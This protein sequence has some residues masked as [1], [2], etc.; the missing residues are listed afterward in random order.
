MSKQE[1]DL[2]G[3]LRGVLENDLPIG[4]AKVLRVHYLNISDERPGAIFQRECQSQLRT[5]GGL[6][7]LRLLTQL[8]A[9]ESPPLVP[10][11]NSAEA[12]R[13]FVQAVDDADMQPSLYAGG[14]GVTNPGS[15]FS[16]LVPACKAVLE[17]CV[18]QLLTSIP[19]DLHLPSPSKK[20]KVPGDLFK[21][22][23]S[24]V[25][26]CYSCFE[27]LRTVPVQVRVVEDFIRT[28]LKHG[29]HGRGLVDFA[30]LYVERLEVGPGSA[31]DELYNEL[32]VNRD[33][34]NAVIMLESIIFLHD[35]WPMWTSVAGAH[36]GAGRGVMGRGRDGRGSRGYSTADNIVDEFASRLPLC[37]RVKRTFLAKDQSSSSSS[38]SHEHRDF[39]IH[40]AE[41]LYTETLADASI[42]AIRCATRLCKSLCWDRHEELRAAKYKGKIDGFVKKG[43]WQLAM[44]ICRDNGM[45]LLLFQCLRERD[46]F[47]EADGVRLRFGLAEAEISAAELLVHTERQRQFL[48]LPAEVIVP[49]LEWKG[50]S[51]GPVVSGGTPLAPRPEVVVVN[52]LRTLMCA[53]YTL[54]LRNAMVSGLV[55]KAGNDLDMKELLDPQLRAADAY[56]FDAVPHAQAAY[57]ASCWG[58]GSGSTVDAPSPHAAKVVG[59]DAE[60]RAVMYEDANKEDGEGASILQLAVWSSVFIFDLRES[61]LLVKQ[62]TTHGGKTP[63]VIRDGFLAALG[64]RELLGTLFVQPD[65][66]KVGWDFSNA[67]LTMLKRA[68]GGLFA[69][70]FDEVIGLVDL[71]L[72]YKSVLRQDMSTETGKGTHTDTEGDASFE[73]DFAHISRALL[74]HFSDHGEIPS[75]CN[76]PKMSLTDACRLII[77]KPLD[78][79]E[80]LS[81]WDSRPLLEA[82]RRYASLDAYCL[83]WQLW[84]V[85]ERCTRVGAITQHPGPSARCTTSGYCD[86]A[87][88]ADWDIL[89]SPEYYKGYICNI[90]AGPGGS[91]VPKKQG[92]R[93]KK[94][95]Q[96]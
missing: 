63:D 31:L 23:V 65:I 11:T 7:T 88:R 25:V 60:W 22:Y 44:Q 46:L 76:K 56:A 13:L 74:S 57:P 28:L 73:R 85:R 54:G 69:R 59:L 16:N 66:V 40:K 58:C 10:P 47:V 53:A 91:P 81:N 89:G 83:L 64:T 32:V 52:S 5:L 8:V 41:E 4:V 94:W 93:V 6:D 26:Q 14:V 30:L 37:C 27:V 82:Q 86:E 71:A 77:G 79:A 2:L 43:K 92:V 48:Q 72:L 12:I 49:P 75:F 36:A 24:A 17:R 68:G 90:S 29:F 50:F 70:S 87:F 42:I 38:S 67:D 1:L 9:V 45:A 18:Y 33:W 84:V 95:Q 61:G 3:N 20:L 51:Q 21:T 96:K 78:K 35:G 80:Q 15:V 19:L 39:V 55:T 34:K 62:Q